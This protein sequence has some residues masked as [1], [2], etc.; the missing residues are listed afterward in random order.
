M[1]NTARAPQQRKWVKVKKITLFGFEQVTVMAPQ[2][3][4]GPC[5]HPCPSALAKQSARLRWYSHPSQSV[6]RCTRPRP[7]SSPGCSCRWACSFGTA[8]P[9]CRAIGRV[10]TAKKSCSISS[11]T[12]GWSRQSLVSRSQTVDASS[13]GC[14]M[15]SGRTLPCGEILSGN[16]L[17]LS[18]PPAGNEESKP[19]HF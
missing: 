13:P 1:W 16:S 17:P 4:C 18:V 15:P 6:S 12:T 9:R 8:S 2:S 19:Q 5:R 3:L 7:C 11:R 14:S 10:A